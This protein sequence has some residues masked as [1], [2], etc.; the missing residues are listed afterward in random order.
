M[1]IKRNKRIFFF[2]IVCY[3]NNHHQT[4]SEGQSAASKALAFYTMPF[5]CE[6]NYKMFD[7][8][9]YCLSLLLCASMSIILLTLFKKKKTTAG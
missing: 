6:T 7:L 8:R 2:F 5:M 1:L 4:G 3:H 9:T